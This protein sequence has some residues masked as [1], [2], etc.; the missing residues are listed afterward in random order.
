MKFFASHVGKSFVNCFTLALT[1]ATLS[2]SSEGGKEKVAHSQT[3]TSKVW[4]VCGKIGYVQFKSVL[5]HLRVMFKQILRHQVLLGE[6][7][8]VYASRL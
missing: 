6:M 2:F 4:A 5:E 7:T 8:V 1:Q 3:Y